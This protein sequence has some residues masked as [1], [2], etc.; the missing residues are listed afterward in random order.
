MYFFT[1][2]RGIFTAYNILCTISSHPAVPGVIIVFT[3]VLVLIL[4]ST[5]DKASGFVSSTT[6][7]DTVMKFCHFQSPLCR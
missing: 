1:I 6:I 2:R 3:F 7:P 4:N 5:F